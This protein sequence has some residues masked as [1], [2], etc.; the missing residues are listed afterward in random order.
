MNIIKQAKIARIVIR[1]LISHPL[2]REHKMAAVKRFVKWQITSRLFPSYPIIYPFTEKAKLIVKR[3]MSGAT[4]NLY[5]GL[6][7]YYDMSFLLH[8]LRSGDFF[9]DVGANI[10]S[11]TILASAHTGARSFSIEPVPSTFSHLMQNIYVNNMSNKVKALNVATG[12]EKGSVNFTTAYDAGNHV[13]TKDEH[14]TIEVP[15]ETLDDILKD[16]SVPTLIKIDV[17]GF[18]T[19]VIK[20]ASNTLSNPDLKAVIIELNGSGSRYNYNEQEVYNTFISL[21]FSP[22]VYDPKDRSLVVKE[23]LGA[24]NTI[25]IRDMDFVKKRI[26]TAARVNIFNMSF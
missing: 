24:A 25:Y 20:G 15:V 18:E 1:D 13:A 16:H 12:A 26:E 2:N 5:S 10:G 7:E 9:V 6:H 3:G 8:F 17:E 21:G 19:E 23:K 22:F 11:Y 14:N 4:G